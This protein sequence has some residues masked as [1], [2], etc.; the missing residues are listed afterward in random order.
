VLFWPV[1]FCPSDETYQAVLKFARAG[2]T[3]YVSGDLSLDPDRKRTR[4]QRLEQLAGVRFVRQNYP[5]LYPNASAVRQARTVSEFGGLKPWPAAPCIDVEA[6]GAKVLAD[7]GGSPVL[8]SHAVG[9]G[10][11]IFTTDV[12]EAR[13]EAQPTL[14]PLYRAVLASAGVE[15]IGIEPDSGPIHGFVIPTRQG[16]AVY[17]LYNSDDKREH[18]A[19]LATPHGRF[20]LL[21]GP[22]KPGL[23][24]LSKD[25]QLLAVEASGK[26]SW[27][28]KAVAESTCHF[29]WF[30][31][32][33]TDLR[34]SPGSVLTTLTPGQVRLTLRATQA[35]AYGWGGEGWQM[36]Q[37]VK[38]KRE[39]DWL[40]IAVD[41]DLA[42]QVI[43]LGDAAAEA[44]GGAPAGVRQLPSA[45]MPLK[46]RRK[47][48]G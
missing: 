15:R 25:G 48:G 46:S 27:N 42:R 4:T 2:G 21:L 35:R 45:P 16:G 33:E 37:Q 1:P 39:G 47:P 32:A 8:V 43:C 29:A 34:Q 3:V 13:P 11:I 24:A 14:A 7:A 20:H 23:I 18:A 40:T 6:R 22:H 12:L 17:L 28:G 10:R 19:T 38:P 41:D 9:R 31:E 36:L 5:D 26:V 44:D 30:T